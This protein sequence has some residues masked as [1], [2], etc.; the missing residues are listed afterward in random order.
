MFF[1]FNFSIPIS[2]FLSIDDK[3]ESVN[4]ALVWDKS[5]RFLYCLIISMPL[6]Q[7]KELGCTVVALL[8][9]NY[10]ASSSA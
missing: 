2:V 3:N 1:T 5:F 6:A 8:S 7:I 10:V 4:K 9:Y